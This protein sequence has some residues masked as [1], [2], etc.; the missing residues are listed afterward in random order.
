MWY[1]LLNKAE[2][3]PDDENKNNIEVGGLDPFFVFF[4]VAP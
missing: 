3:F 2:N 1:V 4:S